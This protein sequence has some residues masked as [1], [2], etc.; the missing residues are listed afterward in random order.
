MAWDFPVLTKPEKI[1][2]LE[3]NRLFMGF[4]LCL[5]IIVFMGAV[6]YYLT[7]DKNSFLYSL[8]LGLFSFVLFG[9][10]V[11]WK[12]L[13]VGML[14]KNNEVIEIN[15]RKAEGVCCKWASEYISIVDFSF[16]FP[17]EIEIGQFSRGGE[18]NAIGNR[19]IIFSETSDY[20]AI[21]HD[22]LCSLRY[23]LLGLSHAGKLEVNMYVPEVL[24]LSLWRSFSLAWSELNLPEGE[25]I[26][27]VFIGNNFVMQVD[28]WLQHPGDK[29]RLVVV[30]NP[31]SPEDTQTLTSDG[32]CAWLLAPA[33]VTE[34]LPQKGR[35]YR[36]LNT[37]ST[38]LHSDL[39]TLLKYQ[40]GGME[41]ER[42]WFN[43]ISD[44]N[45]VNKIA[46]V[47]GETGPRLIS[48]F[49]TELVLGRQGGGGI[50]MT[51]VLA[52]LNNKGE[53]T[54]SLIVSR[55]NAETLFVQVKDTSLQK[56]VL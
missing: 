52:L 39:S 16:V 37:D 7:Q 18:Y 5:L 46:Q 13:R 25:V 26:N 34:Q 23:K 3:L 19:A 50:W 9:M 32:A 17:D 49:F 12:I 4:V 29:Y 15:N 45:I 8:I 38:T 44:K 42:L 2:P 48:H 33:G 35:L 47:C 54:G 56:E 31:L 28:E 21:F 40:E 20:I 6:Y 36:A 24:S 55:C 43:N 22:L 51:M 10:A 53:N 30:C 41:I 27:P 11:G 14:M 1:P